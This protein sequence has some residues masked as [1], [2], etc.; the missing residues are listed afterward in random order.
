VKRAII[1]HCW[2]GYPEYCWYPWAKDKLVQDGFDVSIPALPETEAP[3]QDKWVPYLAD[4][5][6]IPDEEL[7]L[8]GHSV[9]CITILR[10]L[11]TLPSQQFVGGVV[12]VAGFTDDLG[13]KELAN[14]FE[15]PI[16]F[17]GIKGR[18]K[19]GFV[20]ICSDN[21]PYVAL[22]YS[23]ILKEKLGAEV[24]LKHAMGHF[25]GP[26]ESETSCI[27]LPDVVRAV[28]KLSQS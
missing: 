7:F 20:D 3:R 17:D 14:F 25:S 23:D 22:K 4:Q 12:F 11:E 27:E 15:S 5:V 8:I 2:E 1:V 28:K 10:Y 19:N 18:S 24:I 6:G 16:D 13:F 21:D 9:G 26:I